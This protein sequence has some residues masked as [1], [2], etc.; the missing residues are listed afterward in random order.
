M[1]LLSRSK[2]A[3]PR[4]DELRTL[5]AGVPA[6]RAA[7]LRATGLGSVCV[8]P[9]E[10]GVVDGSADFEKSTD[11]F[12]YTWLTRRTS[13]DDLSTLV[14]DLHALSVKGDEAGFGSALLCALVPFSHATLPTVGLV[15]RYARGAWYPFAPVGDH[16]R[17]NVRE[18]QLRDQL[19]NDLKIDS[20]LSRWSPVWGAPGL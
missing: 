10:G 5:L 9:V 7:G 4:L 3:K 20:D 14:E 6:L 16:T 2:P 15:Y 11:E 8:K 1:G 19:G 18:L 13:P 17:D 12:G